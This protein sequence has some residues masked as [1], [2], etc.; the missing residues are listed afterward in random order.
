M[1]IY[2]NEV[3]GTE[4]D[5]QQ[6]C[7]IWPATTK[8]YIHKQCYIYYKAHRILSSTYMHQ[9]IGYSFLVSFTL[10]VWALLEISLSLSLSCFVFCPN[11]P[12]NIVVKRVR[13][14]NQHINNNIKT[15]QKSAQCQLG[16]TNISSTLHSTSPRGEWL[17]L[18][19]RTTTIAP[20]P[21]SV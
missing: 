19:L 20:P 18:G 7:N 3:M 4:P 5:R 11:H 15:T 21:R 14:L 1:V 2:S 13:I 12:T 9:R 8:Q 6:W 16:S 10:S 17:K